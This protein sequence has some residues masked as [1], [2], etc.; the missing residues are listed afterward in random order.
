MRRAKTKQTWLKH[1][2]SSKTDHFS[3]NRWYVHMHIDMIVYWLKPVRSPSDV[4][5]PRPPFVDDRN[6]VMRMLQREQQLR[7]CKETQKLYDARDAQATPVPTEAIEDSIQLQVLP[8]TSS[9]RVWFCDVNSLQ[10]LREHCVFPT[11]DNL[12]WYRCLNGIYENDEEVTKNVQMYL[13]QISFIITWRH[14]QVRRCIV[15]MTH[16]RSREGDLRPGDVWPDVELSTLD[17]ESIKLS[18]LYSNKDKPCVV[19]GASGSWPPFQVYFKM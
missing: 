5:S 4:Q 1:S 2:E 17:G 3:L 12:I 15:Y 19:I 8:V 11:P 13:Q 14:V 9:F 7:M 6:L 16:D 10:V 18:D